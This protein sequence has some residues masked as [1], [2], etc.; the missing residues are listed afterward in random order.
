MTSEVKEET[1]ETVL[2]YLDKNGNKLVGAAAK[3][4]IKL[5]ALKKHDEILYRPHG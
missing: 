4:A 1:A 2:E 3:A 5:A